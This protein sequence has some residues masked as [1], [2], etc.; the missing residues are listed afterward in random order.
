MKKVSFTIA[1]FIASGFFCLQSSSVNAQNRSVNKPTEIVDSFINHTA[2]QVKSKTAS[3]NNSMWLPQKKEHYVVD[4]FGEMK[5]SEIM[6][7]TYND[8]CKEENVLINNYDA[9]GS[10]NGYTNQ[11]NYYDDL[12]RLVETVETSSADG[13]TWKNS[14]RHTY[15]YD[16]VL[17]DKLISKEK[18]DY[19]ESNNEWMYDQNTYRTFYTEVV[20]DQFGRVSMCSKWRNSSKEKPIGQN[21]ITYIGDEDAKAARIVV[22]INDYNGGFM[23]LY[24]FDDIKWYNTD[25]QLVNIEM[26]DMSF[27]GIDPANCPEYYE[28]NSCDDQ[29]NAIYNSGYFKAEYDEQ[30]RVVKAAVISAHPINQGD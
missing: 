28:L 29:G 15:S 26:G 24:S 13:N 7:V 25:N 6:Y 12:G 23:P 1:V 21:V 20:R 3:A 16:D 17:K 18:Y 14:V 11:R 22:C 2:S 27:G 8:D 4:D 19:D 10:L 9:F 5:L 30:V